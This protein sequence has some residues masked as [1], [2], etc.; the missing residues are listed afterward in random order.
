MEQKRLNKAISETGFSSRRGADKLIE[1]GRVTV[2]G[3]PIV[4]GE[5]VIDTDSIEVDGKPIRKRHWPIAL[6]S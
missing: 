3:N 4:L 6:K 2:N 1:A 5:K